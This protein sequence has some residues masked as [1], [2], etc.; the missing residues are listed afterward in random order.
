MFHFLSRFEIVQYKIISDDFEMIKSTLILLCGNENNDKQ[1]SIDIIITSG[2]TGFSSRDV[3]PEA[4][5][6]VIEKEAN[7]LS[8]AILTNCLKITKFAALSRLVCGIRNK[9]LIVNFPGSKKA[10]QECWLV[11]EPLVTHISEL[12]NEDYDS[13]KEKHD[14]LVQN[15]KKIAVKT[16]AC[17]HSLGEDDS[18][19]ASKYPMI[20]MDQVGKII[21]KFCGK[22]N[23][24]IILDLESCSGYVL[25]ENIFAP[26]AQPNFDSSIKDGYAVLTSDGSGKRRVL[27]CIAATA[28]Q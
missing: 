19:R 26:F 2:G 14:S 21:D 10:V 25:G 20:E 12:L 24:K 11:L 7:G 27:G 6:A 18:P 9:T 3:T 17:Q 1:K 15:A 22:L 5:K 4:T 16:C 13:V 28:N 8:V 23:R